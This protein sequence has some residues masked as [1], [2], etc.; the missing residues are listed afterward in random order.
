MLIDM[1]RNMRNLLAVALAAVFLTGCSAEIDNAQVVTKNGLMYKS[2]DSDPFTGRIVNLPIGLPGL[3]AL[4]NTQV[5]KGRYDGKSECFYDSKKVYE[6]EYAAGSKNG[7]ET[8]FDAK[9]GT[10]ISVKNWKNGR[11]DGVAEEYQNG[12][13]THQ[14]TFKEGK[15]D[16]QETRWNADGSK[17]ITQLVWSNG[18]KFSGF[19]TDSNGKHNYA[20][21]QLHGPQIKFDYFAGSL[22]NF[23]GAEENYKDG[24]LDGVQKKYKNI[25]HTDIVLQ[26]S[27]LIYENGVAV[28][29]WVRK[30]DPLDGALLQE[31]QL[32]RTPQAEDEDFESDYPGNLVPVVATTSNE[33][34]EDA[35]MNAY[36][37]EVGE[38]ALIN[39]EQIGEWESWCAEGKRP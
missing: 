21:G 18:T 19:E 5:E 14:Q 7:T 32:V 8:V 31:V 33:S 23:V 6:V 15:P 13:L 34:C 17:V 20:N 2:G 22:K 27:E 11:Q 36:R 12:V 38:D 9:S 10:T 24:K 26:A 16:A 3:T 29:G 39:S 1:E 35:W 4:C 37:A 25:L 30:F 28:S